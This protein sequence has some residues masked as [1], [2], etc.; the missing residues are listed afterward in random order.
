MN[1]FDFI[2]DLLDSNNC[3]Y[4]VNELINL[5]SKHYNTNNVNKCIILSRVSTVS[6]HVEQQT[7]VLKEEALHSGYKEE[8]MI[9]IE[10]HESAIKNDLSERR[11]LQQTMEYINNDSS[12]DCVFI[13]EISRLARRSLVLYEMRDFFIDKK[14][15]LVC[16][17]PYFKLLEDGKMSQTASI[18]FSLMGTLAEQEMAIKLER[19]MRAKNYLKQQGKKSAGSVKFGYTKNKD[20]YVVIDEFH[21]SIVNDIFRHYIEDENTSLYETYTWASGKWPEIFPVKPY[22][23]A[24]HRIRN[25]LTDKTY[26][27]SWCYPQIISSEMIDK[28]KEKMSKAQSKPRFQTNNLYLGRGILYCKHCGKMM[29]PSGGRTSAYICPTD[30]KHNMTLNTKGIDRIIWDEEARVIANINSNVDYNAQIYKLKEQLNM[31]KNVKNGLL[32]EENKMISM[33][34]KLVALY[35]DNKINQQIFD[36]KNVQI[37]DDIKSIKKKLNENNAQIMELQ[38]LI[39]KTDN[40]P[41]ER[42]DIIYDDV[43]DNQTKIDI[44]RKYISKVWVTK[45][46][47]LTYY[48]EFEYKNCIV[49]QIGKYRYRMAGGFLHIWRINADETEDRIV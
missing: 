28:A 14:V 16:I 38:A 22:K 21:S 5:C 39:N 2:K 25:I 30:K 12:I 7:N 15:Q 42:K 3:T 32:G 23:Y 10:H 48:L 20:K 49:P 27:G 37:N 46:K 43:N 36:K 9:V 34:E 44:I 19:F 29:T 40:G 1:D 45:E 18:L 24:Q 31:L 8:N 11:G 47:K 41:F 35:L 26:L 33:Q 6:Q 17:K 4:D 13:Y